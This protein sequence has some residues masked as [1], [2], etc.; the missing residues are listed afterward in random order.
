MTNKEISISHSTL[1]RILHLLNVRN[2]SA[3]F[4]DASGLLYNR[5]SGYN[6]MFTFNVICEK[7]YLLFLLK[8]NNAETKW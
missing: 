6:D 7:K 2:F 8:Y 3:K 1:I 4:T 5:Y